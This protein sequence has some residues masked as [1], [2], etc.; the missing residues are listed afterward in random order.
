MLCSLCAFRGKDT[1]GNRRAGVE[2]GFGAG[3]YAERESSDTA[4]TP[5]SEPSRGIV[6]EEPKCC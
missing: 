4:K 5:W 1:S 3:T 2:H 6:V